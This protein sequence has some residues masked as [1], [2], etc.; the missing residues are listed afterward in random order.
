[1]AAVLQRSGHIKTPAIACADQHV[2]IA[3]GNAEEFLAY[4][5]W[6]RTL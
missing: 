1:M 5:F 3:A 4:A 6:Y 2:L